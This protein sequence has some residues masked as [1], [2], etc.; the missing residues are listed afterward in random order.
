MDMHDQVLSDLT[1]LARQC[2]FMRKNIE[3][4]EK[5]KS[6][7]DRSEVALEEVSMAIRTIIDDLHPAALDLLGLEVSVRDYL[8]KQTDRT[9]PAEVQIDNQFLY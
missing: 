8:G 5:I 6:H 4:P 3:E 7:L 9:G 2:S 1:H